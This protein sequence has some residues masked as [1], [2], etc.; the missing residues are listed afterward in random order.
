MTSRQW[1]L[2]IAMIHALHRP[3][4]SSSARKGPVKRPE[5]KNWK[6]LRFLLHFYFIRD[7]IKE[8]GGSRSRNSH[9]KSAHTV[10]GIMPRSS[11]SARNS[12]ATFSLGVIFVTMSRMPVTR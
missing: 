1:S 5:E 2:K 4:G 12:D 9:Y 7:R 11:A 10:P 3:S 6:E 8:A